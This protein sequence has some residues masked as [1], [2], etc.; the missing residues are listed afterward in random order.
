[1]FTLR[2]YCAELLVAVLE[3]PKCVFDR[4]KAGTFNVVMFGDEEYKILS[5]E[6]GK[7]DTL[8]LQV[9]LFHS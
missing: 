1:M 8:I 6:V 4:C 2:C 3:V 5:V 9:D 7:R